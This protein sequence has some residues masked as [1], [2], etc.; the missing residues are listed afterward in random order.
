M[1]IPGFNA[2]ASIYKSPEHYTSQQ[3]SS[4]VSQPLVQPARDYGCILG[5]MN[6]CMVSPYPGCLQDC[7]RRRCPGEGGIPL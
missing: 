6:Y 5:C 3:A 4:G 1:K 7:K 2:E